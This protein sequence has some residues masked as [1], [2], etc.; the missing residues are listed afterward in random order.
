MVMSMTDEDAVL[1]ELLLSEKEASEENLRVLDSSLHRLAFAYIA[2][3]AL[4]VP[5]L[6]QGAANISAIE[7]QGHLIGVV[8]CTLVFIGAFY[9]AM[10]VR[11]RNV[12]AVHI[13]FLSDRINDIVVASY[14]EKKKILFQQS[15]EISDFYF[16]PGNGKL[17][18]L[19]Y[20]AFF[21][22]VAV[23]YGWVIVTSCLKG[24]AHFAILVVVE[25]VSSIAFFAVTLKSDGM[26]VMR[27]RIN[28]DYEKWLN[29][30][31]AE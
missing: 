15:S 23:F 22:F 17:W 8:L 20:L 21:V 10:I 11:S 16:G 19:T 29:S 7:S 18:F 3:F 31:E 9:A 13:A 5:A 27:K 26:K 12:S 30:V 14:G 25:A 6:M 4:C 28:S 1:M 24:D 2:A